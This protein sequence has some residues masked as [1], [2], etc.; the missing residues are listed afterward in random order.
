MTRIS[1]YRRQRHINSKR[2]HGVDHQITFLHSSLHHFN[3]IASKPFHTPNM[4]VLSYAPSCA[5]QLFFRLYFYFHLT[6]SLRY[7]S[8]TSSNRTIIILQ[9]HTASCADKITQLKNG[10][11]GDIWTKCEAKARG[12]HRKSAMQLHAYHRLSGR[13]F[14]VHS[15]AQYSN[16]VDLDKGSTAI[17]LAVS[18]SH[19]QWSVECENKNKNN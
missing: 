10:D 8:N 5:D 17:I 12:E 13:R 18:M 3:R 1:S 16:Q 9:L 14:V 7:L 15:S 6:N 4:F 11:D 19:Q 2:Q